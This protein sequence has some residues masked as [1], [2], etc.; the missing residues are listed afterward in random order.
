[1]PTT[2]YNL[3]WDYKLKKYKIKNGFSSQKTADLE[4]LN[5]ILE[6]LNDIISP[7]TNVGLISK[8]LIEF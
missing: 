8:T 4:T 5:D 7:T 1:M 6:N 2:E 3:L